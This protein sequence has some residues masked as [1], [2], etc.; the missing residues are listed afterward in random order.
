MKKY[1][2]LNQIEQQKLVAVVR[3]ESVDEALDITDACIAGGVKVI[4][5]TFTLP[6]VL[7]AIKAA[8]NKYQDDDQVVIGAGTVLDAH[9]ARLA[10]LNGAAFIVSPGFDK[11]TAKICNRY[12][13][14]YLPGA[15]TITEI[16]QA[17]T[18]GVDVIKLFPG[19]LVGPEYISSLKGP[20]PNIQIMPTGGVDETNISQWLEKGAFACGM[21]SNLTSLKKLGNLQNITDKAREYCSLVHEMR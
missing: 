15:I 13:I 8:V 9:T 21:G 20:L 2:T 14:P 10:I 5:L 16:Q 7:E 12:Q 6:N 18:Y 3:G 11:E 4:E 19:S 17:L 1:Y